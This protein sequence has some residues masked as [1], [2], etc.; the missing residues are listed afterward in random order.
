[1]IEG[2]EFGK[3]P[4]RPVGVPPINDVVSPK[5]V[6][7]NQAIVPIGPEDFAKIRDYVFSHEFN[8]DTIPLLARQPK[9]EQEVLSI[10][11]SGHKGLGIER[12][13]QVRKAFPDLL[14]RIEGHSREVYLELEVYSQGF[15]NHGHDDQV[16]KRQFTK[17]G[18][19]VA[20]LC[21]IDNDKRVK[22]RVHRVYELQSLIRDGRKIVW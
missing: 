2:L 21:W 16:S 10:V 11:V 18:K 1:M 12:I 3:Q 13:I 8:T 5:R 20:V 19:P 22:D 4:R 6:W 7:N 9:N 17:D 14:V 15:F